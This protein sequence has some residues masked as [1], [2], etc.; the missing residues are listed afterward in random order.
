MEVSPTDDRPAESKSEQCLV[1]DPGIPAVPAQQGGEHPAA[2]R[3]SVQRR[4]DLGLTGVAA[5]GENTQPLAGVLRSALQEAVADG[6][7]R[8]WVVR[9]RR[10]HEVEV[11][12]LVAVPGKEGVEPG[13][14][15]VAAGCQVVQRDLGVEGTGRVPLEER[16]MASRGSAGPRPQPR[17]EPL[18]DIPVP[19]EAADDRPVPGAGL[20][21]VGQHGEQLVV[22]QGGRVPRG[23]GGDAPLVLRPDYRAPASLQPTEVEAEPLDHQPQRPQRMPVEV[24][25]QPQVGEAVDGT[26]HRARQQRVARDR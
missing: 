5:L 7:P 21:D 6:L 24:E 19:G 25:V 10:L 22:L 4:E 14:V 3:P 9:R 15:G 23:R 12:N 20:T 8:D 16:G 26:G 18:A 11:V 2:Q 1:A 17:Q 13:A